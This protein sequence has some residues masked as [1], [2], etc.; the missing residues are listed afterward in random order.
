MIG[1][2]NTTC[3]KH[4]VSYSSDPQDYDHCPQ[5]IKEEIEAKNKLREYNSPEAKRRREA[6]VIGSISPSGL[7]SYCPYCKQIQTL[8]S[9]IY[10]DNVCSVCGTIIG[11]SMS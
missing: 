8:A 11:G 2:T 7:K 6:I 1:K 4:G 5:C 10:D 9:N 3:P